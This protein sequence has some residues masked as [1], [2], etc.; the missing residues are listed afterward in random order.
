MSADALSTLI[1]QTVT[2]YTTERVQIDNVIVFTCQPAFN[3]NVGAAVAR[4]RQ[5]VN[6]EMLFV[7]VELVGY[8][9]VFHAKP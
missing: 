6:Q 5:V 4:Y 7:N 2:Q 3:A 9:Y 1:A 8:A